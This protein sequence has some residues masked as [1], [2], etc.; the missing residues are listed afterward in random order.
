MI[1]GIVGYT[2]DGKTLLSVILTSQIVYGN[3]YVKDGKKYSKYQLMSNLK[4]LKIPH[5]DFDTQFLPLIDSISNKPFEQNVQKRILLVDEI[6]QYLD[7]RTSMSSQN[8]YI[9]REL[10]QIRKYGF[11]MLYT[12]QDY[13]SLDGRLRRITQLLVLPSFDKNTMEFTIQ[14]TD[15]RL[16]NI[17]ERQF[18]I[19]NVWYSMYNTYEKIGGDINMPVKIKG[20]NLSIS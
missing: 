13:M 8:K 14:I 16:N 18:R 11:E 15:N 1:V 12:L 4:S 20:T 19:S 9:S 5:M 10:F 17:A 2:G 6:Q 7:S 3:V